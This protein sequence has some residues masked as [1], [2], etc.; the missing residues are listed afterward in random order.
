MRSPQISGWPWQQAWVR[1]VSSPARAFVIGGVEHMA[2]AAPGAQQAG[3]PRPPFPSH[4]V[5]LCA[6]CG[7]EGSGDRP[8]G[9]DGSLG[10]RIVR[11]GRYVVFQLAEVAVPRSLFA[12]ILGRIDRLSLNSPS[13]SDHPQGRLV[14]VASRQCSRRHVQPC[15][16]FYGMPSVSSGREPF[17]RGVRLV[18]RAAPWPP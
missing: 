18:R 2:V 7:R 5:L 11:H 14:G 13:L 1:K 4:N 15:A 3:P 9:G 16:P 17:E 8:C 10:A 12:S 6:S